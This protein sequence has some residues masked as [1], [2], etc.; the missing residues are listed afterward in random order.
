MKRIIYLL[1][2]CVL[3]F[4]GGFDAS[5]QKKPVK[6]APPKKVNTTKKVKK[7]VV[8][9]VVKVDTPV[10]VKQPSLLDIPDTIPIKATI[11][12]RRPTTTVTGRNLNDK[13]TLPYDNIRWDDQV[14]RQVIW[15]IVDTREKMNQPFVYEAEEENGSQRFFNILLKHIKEGDITAFDNVN[16]RFTTILPV[17]KL[18]TLL[19]GPK[20]VKQVPDYDKDPLGTLGVFKDTLIRSEFNERAI[21]SFQIKEEVIFDKETSR[22]HW[23]ILGIAPMK[24]VF[25][26]DG[27]FR[28]AFPLFWIYYPDARN[29]L[30]RYEVYNPRNYGVRM[31]WEELFETRFFSS[32]ITKSTL[33]N[34]TDKDL[35]GLVPLEIM[36]LLEGENIKETI[37]NWEQD[38][39]SY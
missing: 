25:N 1:G 31:S 8:A 29:I 14:Y 39:W 23:R 4:V 17:D 9:D 37:F 11:E 22:L 18:A 12:S 16:D 38:Q 33:N 28:A 13:M 26:D 19:A 36:R 15:R 6:R 7:P 3:L 30:G 24:S 10:V 2:V 32:Y 21:S 27:S 5:A 35:A 34:P 20:Y